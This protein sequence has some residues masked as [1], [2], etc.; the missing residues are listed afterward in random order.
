MPTTG[1]MYAIL[2]LNGNPFR[3]HSYPSEYTTLLPLTKGRD[4]ILFN[5]GTPA[6]AKNPIDI[7]IRNE[8]MHR[9]L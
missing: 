7:R 2:S 4:W 8:R 6:V 3:K 5:I 1:L 9:R